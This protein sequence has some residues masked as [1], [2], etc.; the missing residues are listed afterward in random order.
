MSKKAHTS[1]ESG[2]LRKSDVR[3]K[4][5]SEIATYKSEYSMVSSS[6]PYPQT[7]MKVARSVKSDTEYSAKF[8]LNIS[9]IS[10]EETNYKI[11]R[12][13]AGKHLETISSKNE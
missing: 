8:S 1:S 13:L 2:L 12:K 10:R 5:E 4:D 11:N 7:T 9:K 6:D 3:Y